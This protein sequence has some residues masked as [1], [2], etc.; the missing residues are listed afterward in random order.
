M[1]W[2]TLICNLLSIVFMCLAFWYLYKA[3]QYRESAK[4]WTDMQLALYQ[5]LV[6]EQDELIARLRER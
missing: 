3:K 5:R 4:L 1:N 6:T 2:I